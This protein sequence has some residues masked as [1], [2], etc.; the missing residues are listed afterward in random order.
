MSQKTL[1]VIDAVGTTGAA[2]AA[3]LSEWGAALE[4][5]HKGPAEP[6]YKKAGL[7]W[8]DDTADPVWILKFYSGTG[9]LS[10]LSIDKGA[11]TVS[12]TGSAA[13]LG[14]LT[15]GQLLRSD[16]DTFLQA[17]LEARF[18]IHG[19]FGA[20][21]NAG[22]GTDWGASVWSLGKAYDGTGFGS[23]F[24]PG[25]QYYGA[26]WLRADHAAAIDGIG[27]GLYIYRNGT[28]VAAFGA[29]GT[30]LPLL[31]LDQSFEKI[32][33]VQVAAGSAVNMTFD[34]AL[35]TKVKIVGRGLR[36]ANDS[37]RLRARFGRAGGSVIAGAGSYGTSPTTPLGY[38][39][40]TYLDIKDTG[41]GLS[42]DMNFFGLNSVPTAEGYASYVRTDNSMAALGGFNNILRADVADGHLW[43]TVQL[44]FSAADFQAAG[45]ITAYGLRL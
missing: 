18:G 38:M 16:D 24:D 10:V 21:G 40:I 15:S 44:Y 45:D 20:G 33:T 9:W 22:S 14:G 13:K 37:S 39:E 26:A 25:A 32:G 11:G 34:P 2:L 5:T 12:L 31:N 36:P 28:V 7:F 35:Y 42:F 19:G 23:S 27:E 43:D 41:P 1:G 4:S 3:L 6:A 29:Q 8:L 30:H 17:A